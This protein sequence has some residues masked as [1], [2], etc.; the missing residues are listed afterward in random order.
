MKQTCARVALLTGASGGIGAAI[1]RRLAEEGFCLALCGRNEEKLAAVRAS[2]PAS[3]EK[4]LLLPGDLTDE[5]YQAA[6]FSAVQAHFG[7]LDVLINCAGMAQNEPFETIRPEAFDAIMTLNCRVPFFMCQRALPLLRQSAAASIINIASVT[8]HKGYVQQSAY[9]ASKHALAGFTK[10]LAAEVYQQG[11]RVHLISPGGVFTDMVRI[12]RPDLTGQ[13]MI[14]PEDIAEITA[15]L[16]LHR[17]NAVI[18]EIEVHRANKA[19]FL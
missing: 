7:G 13:D 18:D 1:A 5:A 14:L 12:S 10:A 4:I 9:A 17:T 11:I 8:A 19:P 3:D 16:L 6:C 15:F 2:I